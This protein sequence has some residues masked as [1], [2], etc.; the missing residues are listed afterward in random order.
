MKTYKDLWNDFISDENIEKS[1][2]D[3]AKGKKKR[4]KDVRKFL[5]L[6]EKNPRKAIERIR[7]Y[8]CN[9]VN[10]NHT[11]VTIYDGISRKKRVIIV[12][13]CRELIVQHM[14]INALK[15]MFLRGIYERS[16][17]SIPGR[18]AYD[19]KKAIEKWIKNDVKNCKYFLKLDIQK[20]FDS[21][22]H[23]TLKAK[24]EREI[25]DD[26]L[27][28]VLLEII[29]S[30][31]KGLPLGFYTSQ[32]LSMWYLKDLDHYIKEHLYSP[33]YIRYMDD[34]VIF[35][36]N[37]RMLW[38]T[39]DNIVI[40]LE[41]LGLCLNKRSVL[42]RFVYKRNDK[43]YGR[44]LDFMGFRFFRTKT[45]LRRTIYYKMCRKARRLYKKLKP[46]IYELRQMLSYLGYLN[47]TNVYNAYLEYIKPF[48]D[49]GKAK[50]RISNYDKRMNEEVVLCGN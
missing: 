46:S 49:F 5:D 23:D 37:K 33:H 2:K 31:D 26:K 8:A 4:R 16:Y 45:I 3:F 21:I 50:K 27:L 22:P 39:Y 13:S 28:N 44:D 10:D 41:K 32:W 42:C 6:Y 47:K 17:G 38:Q 30:T 15:P 25:K 9:Y 11:P 35:G 14:M 1:I 34:M 24:L 7:D 29:N 12:P 18:G 19:G 36:S 40:Q 20:Y 43:E 48:F